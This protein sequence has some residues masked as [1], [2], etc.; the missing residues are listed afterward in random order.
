[1]V[2]CRRVHWAFAA[3]LRTCWLPWTRSSL[4]MELFELENLLFLHG[5]RI[6]HS[7]LLK[8]WRHLLECFGDLILPLGP[9]YHDFPRDKNEKYQ[10]WIDHSVNQPWEKLWFVVCEMTVSG[11]MSDVLQPEWETRSKRG[12]NVLDLEFRK[13]SCETKLLDDASELSGCQVRVLHTLRPSAYHLARGE[14][15]RCCLGLPDSHDDGWETT[16]IVLCISG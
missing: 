8:N 13:L 15:Q 12:H 3:V 1:M 6:T 5:L 11:V 4:I 7:E 2:H 14:Q 16:R 9:G 10:L